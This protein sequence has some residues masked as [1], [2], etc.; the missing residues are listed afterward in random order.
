MKVRRLFTSASVGPWVRFIYFSRR[1]RKYLF[2]R[3]NLR[4]LDAGFRGGEYI[5]WLGERL[6]QATLVG[7]DTAVGIYSN[8]LESAKRKIR[9]DNV[10]LFVKDLK[11]MEDRGIFDVIY[12][13]DVLEHIPNNEVVI[14][15]VF[16]ALKKDGLFYL[17]MTYDRERAT[18]VPARYLER[19][20]AW[21]SEE[22]V[23]EMR[24][25][26][27]TE[28]LLEEAG[29]T[30]L[31]SRY[32]FGLF[33]RLAWELEQCLAASPGSRFL[34]RLRRPFLNALAM[35]EFASKHPNDGNILVICRK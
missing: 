21:A 9:T 2:H 14:R 12:S 35:L 27:E 18:L 3:R 1:A 29:F 22:H 33:A 24:S 13:I 5:A 25:L 34:S 16:R 20:R 28:D 7:Y 31:E 26:L 19:F 11:R 10:R 30:V 4:V 17:A 23:G 15:N 32:T 8:N 6:P